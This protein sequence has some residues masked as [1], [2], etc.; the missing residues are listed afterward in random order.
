MD[1][2]RTCSPLK[3]S[4]C[5]WGRRQ[6][7]RPRRIGGFGKGAQRSISSTGAGCLS[8]CT[9]QAGSP[10]GLIQRAARHPTPA[11]RPGPWPGAMHF[12]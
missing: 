12:L 3:K 1:K 7:A 4:L 5:R 11:C 6:G 2:R 8:A 10:D 9:A